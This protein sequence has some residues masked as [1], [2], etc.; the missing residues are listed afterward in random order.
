[1]SDEFYRDELERRDEQ[2]LTLRQELDAAREKADASRSRSS[3]LEIGI[4][5][6]EVEIG[7]RRVQTK[8]LENQASILEESCAQAHSEL[9][10]CEREQ[11]E[12][13]TRLRQRVV[14]KQDSHRHALRGILVEQRR[15]SEFSARESSAKMRLE[16]SRQEFQR[17]QRDLQQNE[18]EE[19]A[20]QVAASQRSANEQV[21]SAHQRSAAAQ[22]ELIAIR[23]EEQSLQRELT[24]EKECSEGLSAALRH[25][26][27]R[28]NQASVHYKALER[29][30]KYLEAA[31]EEEKLEDAVA[32][33]KCEAQL[34]GQDVAAAKRETFLQTNGIQG[35]LDETRRMLQ[36]HQ[37]QAQSQRSVDQASLKAL[38][39]S[40]AE[41]QAAT[42]RN[43][44]VV[45]MLE[46]NT[47]V[48]KTQMIEADREVTTAKEDAAERLQAARLT[49][50]VAV[51]RQALE[52]VSAEVSTLHTLA[53]TAEAELK[54]AKRMYDEKEGVLR[55]K[56]EDL[57]S[58]LRQQVAMMNAGPLT[59]ESPS[60]E[61]L[62]TRGWER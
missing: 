12:E 58:M 2:I 23:L 61:C 8:E 53:S 42:N 30:L 44:D 62:S 11:A 43:W 45:K 55:G 28:H 20:R 52:A 15:V 25:T 59:S 7:V 16:L 36:D 13:V 37:D 9:A 39:D 29:E 57:W 54:S 46:K 22:D 48:L 56:L 31:E 47:N 5:S 40:F 6:V 35:A 1:M 49:E 24:T 10:A 27:D 60:S 21:E 41:L 19:A 33:T 34:L 18:I 38:Q 17:E 4:S 14:A 26:A 3:G 51:A 50:E 32:A